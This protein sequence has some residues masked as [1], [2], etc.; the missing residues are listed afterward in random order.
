[1]YVNGKMIPIKT[2]P[3]IEGGTIK[4]T[5]GGGEFNYNMFDIL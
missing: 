5:N 2:I 4:E 3:G 1:M